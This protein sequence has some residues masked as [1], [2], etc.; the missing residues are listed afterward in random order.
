M[1]RMIA[2]NAS[3]YVAT[4][5]I[6][7]LWKHHNYQKVR[8]KSS[9]LNCLILDKLD[10]NK[11]HSC[12][13][14]KSANNQDSSTDSNTSM[15]SYSK[16]SK[17]GEMIGI[18]LIKENLSSYKEYQ[19]RMESLK[20]DDDTIDKPNEETSLITK[21]QKSVTLNLVPE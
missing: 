2:N 12:L 17:N 5:I 4:D 20:R 9:A 16:V 11:S 10:K 15:N 1:I 7:R 21:R 18:D 3:D 6:H 13:S 14:N 19:T 8:R